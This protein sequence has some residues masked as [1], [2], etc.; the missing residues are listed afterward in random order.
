M[1]RVPL[2]S[3]GALPHPAVVAAATVGAAAATPP[4]TPVSIAV[5]SVSAAAIA[6]SGARFRLDIA[7]S[8]PRRRPWQAAPGADRR[9]GDQPAEQAGVAV[10]P[11]PV[12]WKPNSVTPPAASCPL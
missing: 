1:V 7:R 10:G 4:R 5:A 11:V 8:F 6:V 3:V 9:G 2:A 12:P